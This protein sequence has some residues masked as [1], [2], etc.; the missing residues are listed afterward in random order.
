MERA[1]FA[2]C[3]A[4]F[5]VAASSGSMAATTEVHMR[6]T[7]HQIVNETHGGKA[8]L[9][10]AV[11]ALVEAGADEEA[12]AHRRRLRNVSNAKLLHL[13]ALGQRVKELGGREAIVKRVLELKN[14]PKD[15][16]FGDR[17]RKLSLGRLVDTLGALERSAKAAAAKP[18][19]AAVAKPAAA[20]PAKAAAKAPKAAARAGA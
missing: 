15:H 19:K 9:I 14:Q 5:L 3:D 12:D 16:E 1:A 7:P 8:G 20:K 13:L 6:K 2:L 11:I 17:L 4:R 18:A 10:D